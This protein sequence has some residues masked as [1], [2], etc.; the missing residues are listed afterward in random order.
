M[1]L[2]HESIL[3]LIGYRWKLGYLN[4]R[5]RYATNIGRSLDFEDPHRRAALAP[6]PADRGRH[7][8]QPRSPRP[9]RWSPARSRTTW[10]SFQSSGLLERYGYPV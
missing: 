8:M 2:T 10:P 7:A 1:N 9:G 5:H 3:K 4:K 6:G